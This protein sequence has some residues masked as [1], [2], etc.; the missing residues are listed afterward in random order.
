MAGDLVSIC[1]PESDCE[2]WHCCP[3][4][5][6]RQEVSRDSDLPVR[7]KTSCSGLFFLRVHCRGCTI[8]CCAVKVKVTMLAVRNY[9]SLGVSLDYKWSQR[10]CVLLTLF[11]FL[12][13]IYFF[14]ISI[15]VC[16][17]CSSIIV[18]FLSRYEF[19]YQPWQLTLGL[20]MQINNTN[21]Y[22]STIT[23]GTRYIL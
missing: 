22:P 12:L 16:S 17:Y 5:V 19:A 1:S 4:H 6:G 14:Y 2:F 10:G 9:T 23:Q 15:H 18:F 8:G 21:R 20:I 13:R 11:R 3:T 7:S